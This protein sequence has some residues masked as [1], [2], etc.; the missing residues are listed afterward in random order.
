MIPNQSETARA[1]GNK[2]ELFY[3]PEL[4]CRASLLIRDTFPFRL[5]ETTPDCHVRPCPPTAKTTEFP[6]KH[7]QI[8][9]DPSEAAERPGPYP[10]KPK[11][12]KGSPFPK[13][14]R[15]FLKL[16]AVPPEAIP[17]RINLM[18]ALATGAHLCTVAC[19]EP[20][21]IRF[22]SARFGHLPSL[23]DICRA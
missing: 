5:N 23:K 18:P 14:P 11:H 9:S 19:A 20:A 7:I 22:K 21:Q 12:E 8:P 13:Q 10:S 15:I 16:R 2:L 17:L 4:T 3:E 1:D 6:H